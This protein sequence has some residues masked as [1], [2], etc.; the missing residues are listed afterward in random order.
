L[1]FGDIAGPIPGDPATELHSGYGDKIEPQRSKYGYYIR[2]HI[3]RA[4]DVAAEIQHDVISS[5]G[6]AILFG[7]AH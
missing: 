2:R 5:L 1:S 4:E 3:G 6:R 7:P